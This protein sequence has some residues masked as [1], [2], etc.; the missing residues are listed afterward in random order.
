MIAD[1]TLFDAEGRR[2]YLTQDERKAFLRAARELPRIERTFCTLLHD[3]GCRISE[4]LA[5]TGRRIDLSAKIVI[6]ETLKQRRQ[7]VFRS[8]PLSDETLDLLD[9]VHGLGEARRHTSAGRLDARLWPF[10]RVTGWR[11]VRRTMAAG[12]IGEGPHVSPKGLRH[13]FGMHA[14]L[15][16][17]PVTA[18]RKWMGHRSLETTAIYVDAVGAESRDLA[19]R[20]W[21]E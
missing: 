12:G 17:I 13:A 9:M 4:A 20:M 6:F 14:I 15:S 7:G 3:T 1:G 2:L 16:G 11:I 5:I 21:E 8:V 18:L 10:N 19:G